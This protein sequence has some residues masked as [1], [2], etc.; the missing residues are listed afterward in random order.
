MLK[1]LPYFLPHKT[2]RAKKKRKNGRTQQVLVKEK[3]RN[4]YLPTKSWMPLAS[5]NWSNIFWMHSVS[6]SLSLLPFCRSCSTLFF[7]PGHICWEIVHMAYGI[8]KATMTL[9]LLTLSIMCDKFCSTH[10]C[11]K[12]AYRVVLFIHINS[13]CLSLNFRNTIFFVATF[14]NNFSF[15]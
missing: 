12:W 10:K 9:Y 11:L 8:T 14:V 4:Y 1:E 2:R 15:Y 6:L 7:S 5:N 13:R 3:E